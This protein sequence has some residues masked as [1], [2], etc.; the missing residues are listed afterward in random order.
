MS[1]EEGSWSDDD[2]G[3]RTQGCERGTAWRGGGGGGG[4]RERRCMGQQGDD[5]VSG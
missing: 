4:W 3:M 5:G 1:C 2:G